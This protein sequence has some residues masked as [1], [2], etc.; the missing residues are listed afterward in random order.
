MYADLICNL[1]IQIY[2]VEHNKL[3]CN[4]HLLSMWTRVCMLPFLALKKKMY[5]YIWQLVSIFNLVNTMTIRYL[6]WIRNKNLL[7]IY[8]FDVNWCR[9]DWTTFNEWRDCR[10]VSDETGSM[11][12]IVFVNMTSHIYSKKYVYEMNMYYTQND[13]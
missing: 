3:P 13:I 11:Y 2:S 4:E 1:W 7:F 5:F 10:L 6:Q 12:I 9:G 8:K